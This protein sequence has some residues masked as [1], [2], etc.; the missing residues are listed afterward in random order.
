MSFLKK[1]VSLVLALAL[2]A[3]SAAAFAATSP[4]LGTAAD[5]SILAGSEVTNTGS[6]D[7]ALNV[8][9]SPGIGPS[10]HYTGFGSVNFTDG[11][12]IHDAD[13][14][15]LIAQNDRTTTYNAL[16]AQTCNTTYPGTQDLV[17]LSLVPGV[18]CADAF[19]LTGTLTLDGAGDDVWI[20]KSELSTLVTTGTTANIV[21]TGDAQACNV[22]W[23]VASSA[24]FDEDTD[25]V[26]NV[27]AST[28]I[29][30]DTG[31]TL[32][33]RALAGT[34]EV[35]LDSNVITTGDAC[36][37]SIVTEPDEDDDADAGGLGAGSDSEAQR[38]ADTGSAPFA[39]LIVAS[40][41]L[42]MG[43]MA[44]KLRRQN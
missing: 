31:A 24:T 16:S 15:A 41:T 13:G 3:N 29:T 33:G 21:F 20:F 39:Y 6:T 25:F 10:P 9:I 1:F 32:N 19:S 18:Y 7:I 12:V 8:G 14:A 27:L 23:R 44:Y 26:G 35:T 43:A 28:S 5:Y 11:G 42:L 37:S 30:F 17:G 38:L 40:S 34:A 36:V 22:W 4:D 2:F